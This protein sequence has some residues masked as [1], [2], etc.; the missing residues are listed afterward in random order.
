MSKTDMAYRDDHEY[1]EDV[2]LHLDLYLEGRDDAAASR[3]RIILDRLEMNREMAV[4][5]RIEQILTSVPDTRVH[6]F[7]RRFL[8]MITRRKISRSYNIR[9]QEF[10][11]GTGDGFGDAVNTGDGGSFAPSLAG[12][13]DLL[14]RDEGETETGRYSDYL[15]IREL[16][17]LLFPEMCGEDDILNAPVK[18]DIRLVD[19]LTGDDAYIPP[20]IKRIFPENTMTPLFMDDILAAER[21]AIES[22]KSR[23]LLWGQGGGGKKTSISVACEQSERVLILCDVSGQP[24]EETLKK[25]LYYAERECFMYRGVLAVEGIE[26]RYDVKYFASVFKDTAGALIPNVFFLM[27]TEEEPRMEEVKS[28]H[29]GEY[30][31][32]QRK[33]IWEAIMGELPDSVEIDKDLDMGALTA[34]FVLPPGSMISALEEAVDQG[35]GRIVTKKNLYS[36]CYDQMDR[37]LS[38]KATRINTG[39]TWE[40]LKLGPT[41]TSQ[42]RDIILSVKNRH[43]VLYEWNFKKVLPYGAGISVLFSGSPGTGKTMAAGVIANELGMEIYK[44][45]LSR[46]IDKYVG[47]TEKNIKAIFEDAKK[48]S[49]ILFFDEADSIFNKRMDV[50]GAN[51]RFANIESS[52]L[53]QCV[54][55]YNGISILATNDTGRIDK[56]FMRRFK[57]HVVFNEPDEE[58]R[59]LIWKGVFPKEAVLAKDVDFETLAR[60]FNISGAMIKNI[61]VAAAYLAAKKGKIGMDDIILA[62]Y[63]EVQKSKITP[64]ADAEYLFQTV[65]GGSELSW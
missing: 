45:D 10:F 3:E 7:L 52:L 21:K 32:G 54:E 55:E 9:A 42:L 63:R 29:V 25:T 2:F 59:L 47:E 34:T 18:T 16:L 15:Y 22:D 64:G 35:D 13:M 23:M 5:P 28:V 51:E 53:L 14:W 19:F 4:L 33:E 31:E 58:T 48:M 27:D 6:G 56:A 65:V 49:C 41:E 36:A 37:T 17:E 1:L 62:A 46:I 30:D 38:D 43:K 8:A 26:K 50:S 24:D 20:D 61:A 40:D 39:Q 12:Y 11:A 44:I 60:I 57:Y